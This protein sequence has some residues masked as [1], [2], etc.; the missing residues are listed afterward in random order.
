M[1]MTQRLYDGKV[2][3]FCLFVSNPTPSSIPRTIITRYVVSKEEKN[4]P[5]CD[6]LQGL[7]AITEFRLDLAF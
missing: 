7:D 3:M 4:V 6:H 2:Y 5:K 1:K